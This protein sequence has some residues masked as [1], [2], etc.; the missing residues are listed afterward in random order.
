MEMLAEW[1]FLATVIA[2]VVFI[3]IPRMVELRR[4]YRERVRQ[5]DENY[6]EEMRRLENLRRA[7]ETGQWTQEDLDFWEEIVKLSA[8]MM[9]DW[10]L[11]RAVKRIEEKRKAGNENKL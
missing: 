6:Q 10:E 7:I 5:I 3:M 8:L 1:L 11:P 2:F 9:P 4:E